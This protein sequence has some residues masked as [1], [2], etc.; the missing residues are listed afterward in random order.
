MANSDY[1]ILYMQKQLIEKQ[2][3]C[4]KCSIKFHGQSIVCKGWLQPLEYIEPYQIEIMQN[5][6]NSPKVFIKSPKI[7]YS[8][9]IHMYK[10]GN[11]CLYYPPDFNWKSNISIATYTIPWV[12][13]W[14]LFYEIYKISGVWEGP[15]APHS[16]TE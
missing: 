3:E 14:I 13:E 16:L 8:T 5:P 1:Q 7:E 2:Y 12:N 4:F 9:K 10:K 15:S 6:G 11:L